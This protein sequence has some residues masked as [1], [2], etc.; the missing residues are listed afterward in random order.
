MRYSSHFQATNVIRFYLDGELIQGKVGEK[1]V[2]RI[3]CHE[4]LG[5]G[6]AH[7]CD[8]IYSDGDCLRLFKPDVIETTNSA[9]GYEVEE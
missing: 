7:F 9:L 8:I 5:E 2:I 3:E 6:D 4:A 1:G